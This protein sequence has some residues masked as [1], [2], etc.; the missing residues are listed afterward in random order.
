MR[1]L[2]RALDP[3]AKT[4]AARQAQ[5]NGP[6]IETKIAHSHVVDKPTREDLLDL[7]AHSELES[8][9]GT[10]ERAHRPLPA[11]GPRVKLNSG[12]MGIDR[13]GAR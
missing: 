8:E 4:E 10:A 6:E 12:Q 7:R 3:V 13:Q 9:R 5:L 1:Q 11:E 2:N